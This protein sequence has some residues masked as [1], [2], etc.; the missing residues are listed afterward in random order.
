MTPL[1]I[2]VQKGNLGIINELLEHGAAYSNQPALLCIATQNGHLNVLE[3]LLPYLN[4]NEKGNDGATSVFIAAKKGNLAMVQ[5]LLLDPRVNPRVKQGPGDLTPFQAAQKYP[6][7]QKLIRD[8]ISEKS[9][10]C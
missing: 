1:C 4:P 3:A 7:I 8:K 9:R 6:D 2:A 10:G 5:A